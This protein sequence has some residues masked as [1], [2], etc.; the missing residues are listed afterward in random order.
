MQAHTFGICR[1]SNITVVDVSREIVEW[2][3]RNKM[4]HI[5][6][7]RKSNLVEL[8]FC[9]SESCLDCFIDEDDKNIS[10]IMALTCFLSPLCTLTHLKCS[11]VLASPPQDVKMHFELSLCLFYPIISS[12]NV[13]QLPKKIARSPYRVMAS[14]N[15]ANSR[16]MINYCHI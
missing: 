12:Q 2:T 14:N 13:H 8:L 1:N 16:L 7:T 5:V 10:T 11:C 9:K 15:K 4:L 6:I 3:K